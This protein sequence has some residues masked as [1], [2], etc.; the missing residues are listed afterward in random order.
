MTDETEGDVHI[1]E[2]LTK[3]DKVRLVKL[4][5]SETGSGVTK[6]YSALTGVTEKELPDSS[7]GVLR[8]EIDDTGRDTDEASDPETSLNELIE[9]PFEKRTKLGGRIGRGGGGT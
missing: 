2:R 8:P 7:K 6:S 4:L 3:R 5:R 1:S 9:A